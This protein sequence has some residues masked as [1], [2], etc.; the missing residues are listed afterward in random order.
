MTLE[1][2]R[3]NLGWSAEQLARQAGINA[4]TVRRIEKGQATYPHTAGAIARA[5]SEGYGTKIGIN[6]IEGLVIRE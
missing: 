1:Q 3:L 6:D 5:L 2:Y 4:Q